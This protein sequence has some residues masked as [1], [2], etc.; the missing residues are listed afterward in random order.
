MPFHSQYLAF[1]T[2][3]L[4][5]VVGCARLHPSGV[6]LPATLENLDASDGSTRG[7]LKSTP[8]PKAETSKSRELVEE[9]DPATPLAQFVEV[10]DQQLASGKVTKQQR[11]QLIADFLNAPESQRTA[12][13]AYAKLMVGGTPATK[14]AA[15]VGTGTSKSPAYAD[16]V[17]NVIE[18]VDPRPD[19]ASPSPDTELAHAFQGS[20]MSADPVSTI[21]PIIDLTPE[22]GVL[23]FA[24]ARSPMETDG[25]TD[26]GGDASS[27]EE[28]PN[29][30]DPPQPTIGDWR[31]GLHEAIE[32]LTAESQLPDRDKNEI[33]KTLL[34]LR[35]LQ[36]AAG[37]RQQ[38]A[39]AIP[40]LD[41]DLR[42]FWA[43]Q[44][45][46]LG[47]CLD[48]E[49]M[50][51]SGRR[52][53]LALRQL[54]ESLDHLAAVSTLD[55]RNAAFCTRVDSFGRY[56]EFEKY[57]FQPGQEVLFYVEIDNFATKQT[58][59]G[60]ESAFQ[61]TY[62]IL[63]PTGR[64][65]FDQELPLQSEI[66]RNRRRDLFIAYQIWMPRRIYPGPYTLQLTVE[67]LKGNK[68]GQTTCSFAVKH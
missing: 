32:V 49:G 61:A 8:K 7:R 47:V 51:V 59:E 62:Q 50:P 40:T 48:D 17:V 65:V 57:E 63:D 23:P 41:E 34:Q 38:A 19:G 29:E 14:R 12:L 6:P 26:P 52:Y 20:P 64:P 68:F 54:R 46:G 55:I 11:D 22:V 1:L 36:L 13:V 25:V 9:P 30:Q 43:Q 5:V 33:A 58:A 67:D 66:C 39:G 45:H 56:E 27:D 21:E 18:P 28:E 31:R 53:A 37:D 2:L 24:K 4:L 42:Q 60:F 15:P 35:L 44:L 10:I 3:A 16:A